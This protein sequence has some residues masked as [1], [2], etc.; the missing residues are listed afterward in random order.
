MFHR[1]LEDVE[2]L[3]QHLEFRSTLDPHTV[4][5]EA[6]YSDSE[7]VND[8]CWDIHY[9][10]LLEEKFKRYL[11]GS[12]HPDHW[13]IRSMVSSD[14]FDAASQDLLL[15]ARSFLQ[16]MTGSDLVPS[17]NH[18]KIVV[19]VCPSAEST[20]WLTCLCCR[21]SSTIKANVKTLDRLVI[22]H[23]CVFLIL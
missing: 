11:R 17:G 18:W 8:A 9:E 1:R 14:E 3:L 21:S 22:Q 6:R 12:G 10:H 13:F 4:E 20:V 15:R 19:R 23:G 2:V 16:L 7:Q 5:S